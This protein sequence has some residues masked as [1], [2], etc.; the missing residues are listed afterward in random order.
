MSVEQSRTLLITDLDNT[1]WDWFRAWHDSFSAMLTR[2]VDL[3]GV[4]QDQLEREIRPI[5]QLRGTSE[6]SNLLNEVPSLREAASPLTPAAAFDDALHVLNSRRKAA[7][8]LYPGVM[9]TLLKLK[10]HG[11]SIVAYTES[12]AYWTEWRIQRTG[13]DGVIDVLYSAEDHDLPA[14]MSVKDLRTGYKPPGEYGLKATA[15]HHTPRGVLK[16]DPTV[17]RSILRDQQCQP[18]R[19]VY[20]GDSLMKDVTMAQSVGVVDVHAKYGEAQSESGYALLRRVSHWSDADVE[21]ERRLAKTSDAVA[22][23]HVCHQSF[24]EVLP[25][26]DLPSERPLG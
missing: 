21:R 9:D 22:P 4:S 8:S 15:H 14:G 17:L 5:H 6:Y 1:L 16:P 7:T 26:F 18:K 19:A 23:T 13:L 11:V 24:A 20:V 12:I 10:Q 25:L 2:L 3:S